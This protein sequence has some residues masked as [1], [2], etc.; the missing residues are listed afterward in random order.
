MEHILDPLSPQDVKRWLGA[1]RARLVVKPREAVVAEGGKVSFFCRA[2]GNPV[3]SVTWKL[4]DEHI[5][6]AR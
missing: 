6:E 5:S 4:N 3:P 2:D 1:D